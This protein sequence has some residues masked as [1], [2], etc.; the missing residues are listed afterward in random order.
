[1]GFPIRDDQPPIHT[2]INLPCGS[3]FEKDYDGLRIWW[4]NANT[5][6]QQDDFAELHEL[7]LTLIDYKVGIIALQE[8][9][10][11]L[12]RPAIRSAIEQVFVEHFGIC[13][14]VLATSPCHSPT[15]WKP[16]GT[17]LVVL[18]SWSHAVTHTGHDSLGRW[19]RATLSG[20]DG[21]LITV[22]SVYN[23]VKTSIA[24]AGPSTIF[25]QQWQVLRTTGIKDP[26]PRKQC[27]TDLKKEID[28]TRQMGSEIILVGDFNE[29]VGA[30]PDLMA[31][32]CAHCDLY[33]VLADR[34]PDQVDT[35]TYI[36]GQHRL[37]YAFA[38]H[39]LKDQVT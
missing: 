5:L 20:R 24:Q 23:V 36:H 29:D 39:T 31:S 10:L 35:T 6:L 32:V 7:C 38:S 3:P 15:A 21:S 19:C 13:K 28:E 34:H 37:D 12:N 18:G 27:I 33:D 30:D 16:G 4:N 26:N 25:A 11:N 8:V 2:P 17:L 22:Y 1:M 14:L 9:N